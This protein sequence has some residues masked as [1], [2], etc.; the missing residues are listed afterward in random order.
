MC[1]KV[2]V[3]KSQCYYEMLAIPLRLKAFISEV[4]PL[5]IVYF[6]TEKGNINKMLLILIFIDMERASIEGLGPRPHTVIN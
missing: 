2:D 4:N 5:W 3:Q 6:L 1:A